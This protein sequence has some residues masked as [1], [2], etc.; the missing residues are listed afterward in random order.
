MCLISVIVPIYK[1]EKY[2][3][4]CVDS[5]LNQT[6]KELEVILVNDGSPDSCPYMCD[7][8]AKMDSRIRV[9]HKK[10][11]GVSTARNMGLVEATGDYITF[12]DSDDYLEQNMYELMLDRAIR[13]NC[14]VVMCDC[15][16]EYSDKSILYTH[17]IRPG[18]YDK[19]QLYNEYYQHLLM[20]ENVE[21]PPTISNWLLLFRRKL[22]SGKSL[23]RYINGVRFSEDLLFGAEL[24]YNAD[25][26]YYLKNEALYH[27]WMNPDSATHV[28]KKDKWEDYKKLHSEIKKRFYNCRDFN[29]HYQI[30][31]TLLFFVYN[32]VGDIIGTPEMECRKKKTLINSILSEISVQ[33]MFQRISIVTLPISRKL[34]LLTYLYKYRIGLSYLIRRAK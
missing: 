4:R 23:P 30:D 20:M 21:Y 10:N 9:I 8:Y 26:F 19:T 32:A 22:Y 3:K 5:I 33:Q 29:F 13:Y 31:L 34:K 15:L 1:A 16:K 7:E 17:D 6:H 2:L 25:S 18:Y 14:D 27:Y 11:G 28:F 12:V 24:L